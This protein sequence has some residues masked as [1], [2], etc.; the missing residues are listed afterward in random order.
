VRVEI[1]KT[2]RVD[3]PRIIVG[4]TRTGTVQLT[5]Q[6]ADSNHTHEIENHTHDCSNHKQSSNIT[7]R[8]PKLNPGCQHHAH[9][10]EVTPV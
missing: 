5:T 3:L 7:P 9:N 1:K 6:R 2:L 8:V 4:S 10:V